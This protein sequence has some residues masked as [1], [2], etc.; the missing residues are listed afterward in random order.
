MINIFR[1][2]IEETSF[3]TM[4]SWLALAIWLRFILWLR[5]I[6]TFSWLIRMI[7]ECMIDMTIFMSVLFIGVTGFADAFQSIEKILTI[8]GTIEATLLPDNP[9]FYQKYMEGY[10]LAWQKSFLVV[11]GE[12]DDNLGDYRD[13]DWLIFFICVIFNIILLL[14][15]LIAIIS[16][17]YSRISTTSVQ[18][19]YRELAFQMHAV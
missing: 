1:N 11:I 10:T 5:S 6:Q 4:Q 7:N 17:T 19:G 2:N 18:T 13:Q 8:E 9:S 16:E 3:W 15:L 14:N 12:F